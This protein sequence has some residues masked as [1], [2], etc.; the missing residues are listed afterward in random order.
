MIRIFILESESV[1][2]HL[3]F[4]SSPVRPPFHSSP[5]YLSALPSQVSRAYRLVEAI[6]KD[7]ATQTVSIL[8]STRLMHQVRAM[9]ILNKYS[10]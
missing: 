4:L 9:Y 8:G 1:F 10:A 5:A 2:S 3:L 7:L 6:S